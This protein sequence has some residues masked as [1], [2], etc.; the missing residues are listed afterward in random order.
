MR[1]P[2]PVIR[3][4][5]LGMARDLPNKPRGL[6]RAGDTRG[7]GRW[8][9]APQYRPVKG[10]GQGILLEAVFCESSVSLGPLVRR[11][12]RPSKADGGHPWPRIH[13]PRT[14]REAS[15][16][17]AE[18]SERR[19]HSVMDTITDAVIGTDATVCVPG[20][21]IGRTL[22]DTGAVRFL[23]EGVPPCM[24]GGYVAVIDA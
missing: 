13:R 23:L 24:I 4:R 22:R 21:I 16:E 5:G 6:S 12:S 19:L 11:P 3:Y 18:I 17:D 14:A 9:G 15:R 8:R 2:R 20:D 10:P 7:H 1:V